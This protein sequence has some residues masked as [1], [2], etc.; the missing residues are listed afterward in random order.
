[1]EEIIEKGTTGDKQLGLRCPRNLTHLSD[2]EEN[3]VMS[4]MKYYSSLRHRRKHSYEFYE[5]L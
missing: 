3:I 5:I 4:C 1:M 2:T